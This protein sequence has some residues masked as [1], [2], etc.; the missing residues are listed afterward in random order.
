MESEAGTFFESGSSSPSQNGKEMLVALSQEL[1]KLPNKLSLEGHTDGRP[2]ARDSNYGNWELSAD[3]ANAA[4]RLMQQSG[5]RADQVMQIRGYADQQLRKGSSPEDA[6]N[7][8]ISLIIQ[9]TIKD[10]GK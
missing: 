8:R 5:V 2:F 10:A 6:S 1:G 9:Y 7:R 4:R 3:R